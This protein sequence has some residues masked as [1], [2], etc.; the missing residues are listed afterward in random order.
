MPPESAT[1]I[2]ATSTLPRVASFAHP[3]FPVCLEWPAILDSRHLPGYEA[4]TPDEAARGVHAGHDVHLLAPIHDGDELVT[5]ATVI[6]VQAARPGAI[7]HTRLDTHRAQS[8]DLVC[9]TFQ[10]GISRGVGVE[11]PDATCR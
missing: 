10:T 1:A 4:C 5:R 9:R 3:L 8:G 7:V 11:G 2:R 6:D